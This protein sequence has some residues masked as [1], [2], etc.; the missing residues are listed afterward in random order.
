MKKAK[1]ASEVRGEV[2]GI[3]VRRIW[4]ERVLTDCQKRSGIS[5]DEGWS[6]SLLFFVRQD[7]FVV[8]H[9]SI[10]DLS[11]L[12]TNSHSIQKPGPY[13]RGG[14]FGFN[15]PKN[16]EKIICWQCKKARPAKCER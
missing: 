14:G 6:T 11:K 3:E 10:S 8:F 4:D 1:H 12:L 16:V 5:E 9:L 15:P 2:V 13:L 7:E